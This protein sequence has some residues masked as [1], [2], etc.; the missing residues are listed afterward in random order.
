MTFL[1]TDYKQPATGGNYIKFKNGTTKIRI[2]SEAITGWIDWKDNKPV[3]T[4]D[5]QS[6][7]NPWDQTKQPKHFRAFVVWD[8][9][10][11]RFKICEITQKWLQTGIMNL[12][13]DEDFWDPKWYDLKIT[14][15]GE[16]MET[17]YS[18]LPWPIAPISEEIQARYDHGSIKLEALFTNWDP[19]EFYV[20][21][22]DLPF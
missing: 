5:K 13:K 10:D 21:D 9:E 7:L 16:K 18:I 6:P 19:F 20:E 11:K 2:M 4:K 22:D 15:E 8:Y 1:P 12:F 17:K 3:R 14:K